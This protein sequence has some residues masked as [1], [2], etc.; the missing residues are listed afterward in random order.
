MSI[1]PSGNNQR[2]KKTFI[3]SLEIISEKSKESDHI[4]L[5][6]VFV[7]LAGKGYAA[8]LILL[9]LPFCLPIQIPGLSTPFGLLLVFIGFRLAFAKRLW[10]PK[11]ILDKEFK[12]GTIDTLC[13]KCIRVVKSLQKIIHP[14]I[15]FLTK[16]SIMRRVHGLL[17]VFFALILSLPLPIPF[18]NIL[19]AVPIFFIGFGLLEDD[20]V[21]IIF[22]YIFALLSLLFFLFLFMLGKAKLMG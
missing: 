14:R 10:W 17:V 3:E 12:S 15:L 9:S 2:G 16:N 5:Q 8:L 1:N 11:W 20:G 19:C 4:K 18:S 21:V 6:D 7:I 22:G 13:Q